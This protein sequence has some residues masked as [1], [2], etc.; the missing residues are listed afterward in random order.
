MHAAAY[1]SL[2]DVVQFLA[3]GAAAWVEQRR[4]ATRGYGQAFVFS[5]ALVGAGDYQSGAGRTTTSHADGRCAV[6]AG[7]P[8]STDRGQKHGRGRQSAVQRAGHDYI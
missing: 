6:Q 5:W 1:G 7:W 3:W 2:L 8:G 4:R